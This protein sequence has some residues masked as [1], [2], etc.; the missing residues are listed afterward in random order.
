[1]GGLLGRKIAQIGC[2][3]LDIG[4]L[5]QG[6]HSKIK[7]SL[8]SSGSGLASRSG[9]CHSSQPRKSVQ[10][11]Q[12]AFR[13]WG[14]GGGSRGRRAPP[15]N[16]P[17]FP[18]VRPTAAH[19]RVGASPAGSRSA[20]GQPA[21]RGGKR[22]LGGGAGRAWWLWKWLG[23]RVEAMGRGAG[24]AGIAWGAQTKFM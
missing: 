22:R 14:C 23:R 4:W 21:R 8:G 18:Q 10:A 9:E 7:P 24:Y 15:G 12:R 17:P 11:P 6:S 16:K 2:S 1:V 19:L 20:R 13:C 3:G 5:T